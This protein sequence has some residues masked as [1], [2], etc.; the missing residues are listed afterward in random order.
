MHDNKFHKKILTYSWDEDGLKFESQYQL[1][2]HKLDKHKKHWVPWN[3]YFSQWLEKLKHDKSLH[4]KI[5]PK[6]IPAPPEF[7][8]TCSTWEF[9]C[10]AKKILERHLRTHA[11][12]VLHNWEQCELVFSA[13]YKLDKHIKTAHKAKEAKYADKHACDQWE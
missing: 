1:K 8:Y 12:P 6:K 2:M 3:I 5:K 9:K 7:N 10:Q 13:G 11:N 4:R